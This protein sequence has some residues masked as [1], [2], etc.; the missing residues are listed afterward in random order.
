MPSNKNE[1]ANKNEEKKEEEKE[2]DDKNEEN[3]DVNANDEGEKKTTEGD[4]KKDCDN[5]KV[6]CPTAGLSAE[7]GKPADSIDDLKQKLNEKINDLGKELVIMA[8]NPEKCIVNYNKSAPNFIDT[9]GKSAASAVDN[10][11]SSLGKMFQKIEEAPIDV[12]I[13][14]LKG[15]NVA[16]FI[17]MDKIETAINTTLFGNNEKAKELINKY[18]DVNELIASLF[19]RQGKWQLLFDNPEFKAI[20]KPWINNYVN[21]LRDTLD[22]AKEPIDNF[23]NE[24]DETIK[25]FGDNIGEVLGKTLTN[26]IASATA[27]IPGVGTV[28]VGAK[29]A[30]ELGEKF[31][32]TCAPPIE[33]GGRI[34][35]AAIMTIDKEAKKLDCEINNLKKKAEPIIAKMAAAASPAAGGGRGKKKYTVKQK[36][37]QTTKR[38]HYLLNRFN[39]RKRK[40]NYTRQLNRRHR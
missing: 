17:L 34:L 33:K 21:S 27:S 10:F 39:T 29:S 3:T 16:K 13:N 38:V 1:P 23:K 31:A 9:L 22:L 28:V 24:L 8:K 4:K 12:V 35:N 15:I 30:A 11:T 36:I 20:L 37:Q 25:G 5:I 14:P 18:P 40:H 32:E 19:E 7:L 26:L 6:K 2:E